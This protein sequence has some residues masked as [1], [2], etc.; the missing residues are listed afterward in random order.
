MQR[1][2]AV[3][4]ISE[5]LGPALARAAPTVGNLDTLV[6]VAGGLDAAGH[7]LEVAVSDHPRD[8]VGDLGRDAVAVDVPPRPRVA[9]EALLLIVAE[10]LPQRVAVRPQAVDRGPPPHFGAPFAQPPDRTAEA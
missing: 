2:G 4:R 1:A 5:G 7:D 3:Q 9:Q 10:T 6:G 8:D